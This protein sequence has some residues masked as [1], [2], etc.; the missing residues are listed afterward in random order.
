MTRWELAVEAFGPTF[1]LS[2]ALIVGLVVWS[3]SNAALPP[4]GNAALPQS[5]APKPASCYAYDIVSEA[6]CLNR[7]LSDETDFIL[8]EGSDGVL[9]MV[10]CAVALVGPQT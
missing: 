1:L 3:A 2:A 9:C 4:R 10:P 7:C 5:P 6:D 8:Y